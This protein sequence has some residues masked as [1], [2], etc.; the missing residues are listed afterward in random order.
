MFETTNQYYC[1][2]DCICVHSQEDS[3]TSY[4]PTGVESNH[5]ANPQDVFLELTHGVFFSGV[6]FPFQGLLNQ[7]HPDP[8]NR[9]PH[10][11]PQIARTGLVE[12]PSSW[13]CC[14]PPDLGDIKAGSFRW[15]TSPV[16]RGVFDLFCVHGIP[17]QKH[18]ERLIQSQITQIEPRFRRQ[19]LCR[20]CVGT[21]NFS[22]VDFVRI[23]I[24]DWCGLCVCLVLFFGRKTWQLFPVEV[25]PILEG[26][27]QHPRYK[28]GKFA[29][30]SKWTS[31]D[32]GVPPT[33]RHLQ[34]RPWLGR[35]THVFLWVLS[36]VPG[37]QPA[38]W[39]RCFGYRF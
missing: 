34:P 15:K 31:D 8:S 28:C 11:P 7:E 13:P 20:Q 17:A 2:P 35:R 32:N 39:G 37:V 18:G 27:S 38:V 33:T 26:C 21:F 9:T 22:K 23:F 16:P 3:S 5:P 1:L 36:A 19:F 4:Q 10:L 30:W 25:D 29:K 12:C 6:D 14:K 24:V